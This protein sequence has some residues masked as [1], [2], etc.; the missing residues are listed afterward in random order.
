MHMCIDETGS[1]DLTL[2]IYHESFFIGKAIT[3]RMNKIL[4]DE[5]ITHLVYV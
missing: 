4:N 1:N 2:T 5:Q 3:H